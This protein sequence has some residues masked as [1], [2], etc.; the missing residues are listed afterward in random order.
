MKFE[1][2]LPSLR[3][4]KKIRRREWSSG[5]FVTIING[6]VVEYNPNEDEYYSHIDLFSDD[7]LAGDWE[8]VE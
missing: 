5:C 7:I 8:V 6:I 4:G 3:E 1:E 2:V